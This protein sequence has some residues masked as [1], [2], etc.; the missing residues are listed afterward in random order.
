MYSLLSENAT[1]SF[2]SNFIAPQGLKLTAGV[3]F[4]EAA[5]NSYDYLAGLNSSPSNKIAG[6]T[7]PG[8]VTLNSGYG[9]PTRYQAGRTI[10]LGLRFT[11]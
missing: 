6:G 10:R 8:P 4:Y 3:P 9:L 5:F 7:G 1:S 11:F 2:N